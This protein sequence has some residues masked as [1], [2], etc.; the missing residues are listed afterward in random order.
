MSWILFVQII[1]LI[2]AVSICVQEIGSIW[3]R[4]KKQ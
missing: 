1:G 4:E 2:I 3:I